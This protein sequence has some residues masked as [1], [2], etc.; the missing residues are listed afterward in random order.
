FATCV[1]SAACAGQP[2]GAPTRVI[3]PRGASFGQA[4]DSLAGAG[5]VGH[6]KLFRLYGR[7]SGGDRN[8]KPGTYLL[9]HGTPWSDIVTAL[10]GGHGLVN[11]VT[12]PEGWTISQITPALAKTLK[13][14]VDSVAAAVRDTAMLAR[15]DLPNP[16][17]EGYLFP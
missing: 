7:F 11:T 6:P 12:I 8:I 10:N 13:V 15:L 2:H 9:K 5:L 17:L 1:V 4:T 14:P 3:I 16:T